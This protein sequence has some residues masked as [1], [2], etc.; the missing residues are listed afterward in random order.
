MK[1]KPLLLSV[2]THWE[3][4]AILSNQSDQNLNPAPVLPPN[5]SYSHSDKSPSLIT[6][7]AHALIKWTLRTL[8]EMPF[9]EYHTFA[10]L[11]WLEKLIGPHEPIAKS[12]ITDEFVRVDLLRLYHQTCEFK[13]QEQ[14][15]FKL[16]TLQLF[17]KIMVCLLEVENALHTNVIKA[18]LYSTADDLV[19][20]GKFDSYTLFPSFPVYDCLMRHCNFFWFLVE[21][22]L[23]LLSLYLPE[24]W[25]GAMVPQLLLT[26]AQLITRRRKNSKKK[27]RTP[28]MQICEDI[29]SAVD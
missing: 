2:L 20:R 12:L 17:T 23:K 13:V 11:K 19:K 22:G 21:A 15:T 7:T 14:S 6:A 25:S 8:S 18:C 28:I 16:D 10:T 26:H 5:N 1:C 24:I 27:S 9:D 3:P 4:W 29:L